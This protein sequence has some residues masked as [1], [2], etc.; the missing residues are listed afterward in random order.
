M[1]ALKTKNVE[2]YLTRLVPNYNGESNSKDLKMNEGQGDV[3][4]SR[5]EVETP[6]IHEKN[7]FCPYLSDYYMDCYVVDTY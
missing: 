7:L 2:N 4:L 6:K 5:T 1:V 3:F